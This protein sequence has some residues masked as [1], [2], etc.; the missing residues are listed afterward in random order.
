MGE[1]SMMDHGPNADNG[2]RE[3]KSGASREPK[4]ILETKRLKYEITH[5]T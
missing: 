5:L 3:G 1:D 2:K 4:D